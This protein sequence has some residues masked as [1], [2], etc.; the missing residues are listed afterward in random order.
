MLAAGPNLGAHQ[1]PCV[2]GKDLTCCPGAD[3]VAHPDLLPA[4]PL[5]VETAVGVETISPHVVHVG[6]RF[7]ITFTPISPSAAHWTFPDIARKVSSCRS[8]VDRTCTYLARGQDVTYPQFAT[9]NGWSDYMWT[10]GDINGIGVGYDY[11]AIVGNRIAVSGRLTDQHG[12]AIPRG[13]IVTSPGTPSPDPGVL[14]EFSVK[15]RGVLTAVYGAAPS[16][17]GSVAQPY[18]VGYY[19]LTVKPGTY[20]IL[21]GDP[22]EHISC[23]R[24]VLRITHS[25]T[26]IDLVCK[27]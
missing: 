27:R 4:S 10:G 2:P 11:Y 5:L 19:G 3:C 17:H 24:R 18:D 15:R 13:G 7:K 6:Q 16:I 21:A 22:I 25:V 20:T 1:R 14:I 12:N 9:Y 8:G 23:K 26:N